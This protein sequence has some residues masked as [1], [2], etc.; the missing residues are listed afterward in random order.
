[1]ATSL[2]HPPAKHR[3]VSGLPCRRLLPSFRRSGDGGGGRCYVIYIPRC[4]IFRYVFQHRD[5]VLLANFRHGLRTHAGACCVVCVFVLAAGGNRRNPEETHGSTW[6]ER[7]YSNS[8]FG[9]AD[10]SVRIV[11]RC[12]PRPPPSPHSA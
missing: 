9:L 10:L 5:V 8:K 4:V 3:R 7:R 6:G 12:S 2:P 1:M 11:E